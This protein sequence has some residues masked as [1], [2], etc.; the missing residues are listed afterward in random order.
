[1]ASAILPL[2]HCALLLCILLS[3]YSPAC[4]AG[5]RNQRIP[6]ARGE[7]HLES[8]LSRQG[9]SDEPQPLTEEYYEARARED[10][11][12]LGHEVITEDH[13]Y[14]LVPLSEFEHLAE[15]R[16]EGASGRTGDALP[17]RYFNKWPT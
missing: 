3:A 16:G 9:P 11:E 7:P 2:G 8:W 10:A 1:M 14:R 13:P 12:F 6:A 15:E 4:G 17:G 5:M